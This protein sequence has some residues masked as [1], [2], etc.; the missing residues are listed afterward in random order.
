MVGCGTQMLDKISVV[1]AHFGDLAWIRRLIA[2]L[3]KH[4]R[5]AAIQEILIVNQARDITVR[6]EL[7]AL[8]PL[9]RVLEYPRSERHFAVQGHDHAAV[10]NQACREVRGEWIALFD[11]DCFP[12]HS[13]WLH[14]C[15]HLLLSYDALLAQ[16]PKRN[17]RSHPCFMF[18]PARIAAS[19]SFDE[20]L[21]EHKTD[22]GRLVA[23]Q[24]VRLSL[25]P[26]LLEPKMAQ[27][28]WWGNL[29]LES[30]YHHGHGSFQYG[31][32][33]LARQCDWLHAYFTQ[34]IGEDGPLPVG[35]PEWLNLFVKHM[36]INPR[37]A[38]AVTVR[39]SLQSLGLNPYLI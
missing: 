37:R 5:E 27:G 23:R 11:S 29:Y 10:L 14:R 20:G 26:K 2:S 24:L 1:T 12:I 7:Q 16:E 35:M 38:L 22:T 39:R 30:L 34:R 15:A 32:H 8:D 18:L 13:D 3:R 28:G 36:G 31:E 9:G 21:F 6:R 33:R 19:L 4:T 17:G 25:R